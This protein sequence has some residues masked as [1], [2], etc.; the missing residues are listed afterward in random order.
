MRGREFWVSK[1][2]EYERSELTQKAGGVAA[3]RTAIDE[4]SRDIRELLGPRWLA[5]EK[6][7]SAAFLF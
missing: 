1:V 4:L 5:L 3:A 6:A 2:A 7:P